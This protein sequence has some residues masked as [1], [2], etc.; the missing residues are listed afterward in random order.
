MS[1]SCKG[2]IEYHPWPRPSH[3][4]PD[5]FLHLRAVAMDGAFLAGG[6]LLAVTTAVQSAMGIIQQFSAA[7][8]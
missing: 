8:A 4:L 1:D 2:M 5:S 7:R 6:F 3:D